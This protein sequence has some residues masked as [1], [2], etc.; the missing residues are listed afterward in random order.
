M[1]T[2]KTIKYAKHIEILAKHFNPKPSSIVQ[3]FK[4]YNR[5]QAKGE[6]IATYVTS[7]HALAEHCEFNDTLNMMLCDQLICGVNH[8][9]IQRRLL[10]EKNLTYDKAFELALAMEASTKVSKDIS[11]TSSTTL[12]QSLHYTAGQKNTFG[13]T[14]HLWNKHVEESSTKPTCYRCGNHHLASEC[15]FRTAECRRCHKTR[16]IAKVCRSRA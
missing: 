15:K 2:R 11:A 16:Q 6:T 1:K 5:T 9:G 3:R 13:K 10:S 14:T 12:D 7:I 8:E 4:F